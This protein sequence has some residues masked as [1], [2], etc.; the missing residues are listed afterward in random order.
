M[1]LL[2]ALALAGW[3]ES[4]SPKP[5]PVQE[6]AWPG[7][8]SAVVELAGG[9]RV[10]HVRGRRTGAAV[11]RRML[12][13]VTEAL[14]LVEEAAG[15]PLPGTHPVRIQVYADRE[16][17]GNY[18][19]NN[20]GRDIHVWQEISDRG[21]IH[22]LGHYW[23]SRRFARDSYR[24]ERWM[25]EG[26]AE[27]VAVCALRGAPALGDPAW[28]HRE[29]LSYWVSEPDPARGIL[30]S[31]I[32]TY[33]LG[34]G[35]SSAAA[36]RDWYARAYS[37]IHL[38]AAHVGDENLRSAHR[39]LAARA[40]PVTTES[41]FATLEALVPGVRGAGSGWLWGGEYA[42]GFHPDLLRDPDDDGLSSAEERARGT[43]EE[44]PD[45][46]GDGEWDGI[47]AFVLG[48]DPCDGSSKPARLA[49][50]IDGRLNEWSAQTTP[51]ARFRYDPLSDLE[52]RAP[53]ACDLGAAWFDADETYFYAV[54][55][56]ANDPAPGARYEVGIDS[57]GDDVFDYVVT[58]DHD[59]TV[60]VG[61]LY[62]VWDASDW[63]PTV[64]APAVVRG[65]DVELAIPRAS[66]RVRGKVR[67]YPF[68]VFQPAD[69]SDW[70]YGDQFKDWIEFELP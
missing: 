68:S 64:V 17:T 4:A 40:E 35:E 54:F 18:A 37:F 65:R 25:T 23:F 20:D 43:A 2:V 32:P 12:H 27:Y 5:P 9:P 52:N 58:C 34:A 66:M 7:D 44:H 15:F 33:P 67:L 55:R 56:L 45:T 69:G 10:V 57:D 63:H 42:E 14:P 61:R 28:G 3:Q 47:E 62:E 19:G 39:R 6:P 22:E 48:T 51:S 38:L 46:D 60:R 36:A 50:E 26:L 16:R 13:T 41:Y 24:S 49:Y 31:G 59:A 70:V 29:N 30:A 1:S 53:A 8:F 11:C 21:L